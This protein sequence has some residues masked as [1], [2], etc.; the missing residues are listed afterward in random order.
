[1]SAAIILRTDTHDALD[2]FARWYTAAVLA[3]RYR[4]A[5]VVP[6]ETIAAWTGPI[7]ATLTP[8][9][10]RVV[11]R[12]ARERLDARTHETVERAAAR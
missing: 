12:A 9:M 7:R 10:W 3:A 2:S 5:R 1:M 11:C 8:T 6:A 4:L